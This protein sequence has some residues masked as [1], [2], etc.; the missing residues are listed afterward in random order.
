VSGEPVFEQA[1]D[2]FTSHL[3]HHHRQAVPTTQENHMT[4]PQQPTKQ[5]FLDAM[6]RLIPSMHAITG[7]LVSNNLIVSLAERR[8][9]K[10]LTDSQCAAVIALIAAVERNAAIVQQIWGRL[11]QSD[12]A[13]SAAWLRSLITG[14]APQHDD[15]QQQ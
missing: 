15:A 3:P 11:Q 9:G 6:A 1:W 8:L 7:E 4:T 13:L 10:A 12:E 14:Q 2:A 5:E